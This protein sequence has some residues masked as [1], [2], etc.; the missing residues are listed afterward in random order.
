[1]LIKFLMILI[2]LDIFVLFKIVIIG[3]CGSLIM[4]LI[5]LIFLFIKNLVVVFKCVEILILDVCL[6]CVVLKV[7]F[8]NILFKDV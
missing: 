6:W 7:L 1:M 5:N 2:L 4:L 3:L 8:I